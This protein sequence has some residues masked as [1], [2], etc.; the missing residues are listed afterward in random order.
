MTWNKQKTSDLVAELQ[1]PQLLTYCANA[2]DHST[3]EAV[4]KNGGNIRAAA[5]EL[6]TSHTSVLR[7]IQR[8]RVAAV[9]QGYSPR[10]D[11][12]KPV[13]EPHEVRGVST[14]YNAKGEVA[15]QW[16]KSQK[17]NSVE[18]VKEA[19][20]NWI[21]TYVQGAAA[22]AKSPADPTESMT[23]YPI[24]DHHL[25]MFA[26]AK[27]TGDTDHDLARG[28]RILLDTSAALFNRTPN[29]TD[30]IVAS[31]GDFYHADSKAN[32]TLMSG[33]P[34]DVDTRWGKV[35]QVGFR[36]FRQMIDRALT[37]HTRVRV[38]VIPGNHDDHSALMLT[39]FLAAWYRNEPRLIVD[40]ER[41]SAMRQYVLFGEVLLCFDHGDKSPPARLAGLIP[42]ERKDVWSRIRHCHVFRGHI[43]HDREIDFPGIK[44][45]HLRVL[46]PPDAWHAGQGYVGVDK[47][48]KAFIYD[49]QWGE[50][51]KFTQ[52]LVDSAAAP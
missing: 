19:V 22:P 33:N 2:T 14:L 50:I 28:E 32:K 7:T 23:V 30:A 20:L 47:D 10:H 46:P 17:G 8:V 52:P 43:H 13:P 27:E 26:W 6:G 1:D 29:T 39:L 48:A 51:V 31:V 24:G 21:D 12:T 16:V 40:T 38:V 35:L 42:T 9:K 41:A 44:I 11:W 45:R 37:K 25:G 15:A 4:V 36:L 5:R 49:P 34:L 3:L 18:A